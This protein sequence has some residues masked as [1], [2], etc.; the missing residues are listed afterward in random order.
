MG[1]HR[2]FSF[3]PW[4]IISLCDKCGR[5]SPDWNYI[6]A[7][8]H[9]NSIQLNPFFRT[10]NFADQRLRYPFLSVHR[11]GRV[12]K[13]KWSVALTGLIAWIWCWKSCMCTSNSDLG[14]F[15]VGLIEKNKKREEKQNTKKNKYNTNEPIKAIKY[16]RWI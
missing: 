2:F 8:P 1:F 6:A 16:L 4:K 15:C 12:N 14:K 11:G 7:K 10:T 9:W 13:K 5:Q 3:S